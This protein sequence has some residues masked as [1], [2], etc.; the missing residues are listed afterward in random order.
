MTLTQFRARI[1]SCVALLAGASILSRTQLRAGGF[2]V[3]Q[4]APYLQSDAADA[5]V[6][7]SVPAAGVVHVVDV[8][9]GGHEGHGHAPG[10]EEADEEVPALTLA[11]TVAVGGFPA[12]MALA[13]LQRATAI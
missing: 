8:D 13:Y 12:V 3:N 5:K 11:R 6:F 2:P 4:T 10:E 1:G 9:H 7:V